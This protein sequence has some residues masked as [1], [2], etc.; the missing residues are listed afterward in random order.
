MV[1]ARN[2][3]TPPRQPTTVDQHI[4]AASLDHVP[5]AP[6]VPIGNPEMSAACPT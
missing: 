5:N 2:S 3:T 4:H 1:L 6:Q